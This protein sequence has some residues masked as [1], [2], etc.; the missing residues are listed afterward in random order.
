MFRRWKRERCFCIDSE[1]HDRAHDGIIHVVYHMFSGTGVAFFFFG[2]LSSEF[3][4]PIASG[5]VDGFFEL[6][7]F[8]TEWGGL[9]FF[10]VGFLIK[11]DKLGERHRDEFVD[12]VGEFIPTFFK[13]FVPDMILVAVFEEEEG[14]VDLFCGHSLENRTLKIIATTHGWGL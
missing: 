10:F 7:D 2:K 6:A 5:F 13:L 12:V 1:S 4:I 9:F 8:E 14:V 11:F 3:E